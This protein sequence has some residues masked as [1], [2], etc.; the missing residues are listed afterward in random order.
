MG[1][2]ALR[3]SYSSIKQPSVDLERLKDKLNEIK[4]R[5]AGMFSLL[6]PTRVPLIK[7]QPIV[8]G[9]KAYSKEHSSEA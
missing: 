7:I 8:G 6:P 1:R 5:D 2:V 4:N 3:W 9:Y